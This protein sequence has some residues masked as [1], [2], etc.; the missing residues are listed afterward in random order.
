MPTEQTPEEIA[1]SHRIHAVHCNNLA[2]RL[3]ELTG[4]TP[5][6]DTEMLNA[7][8]AA[9]FHWSKVGTDLNMARAEMLL[10]HVHSAL[11]HGEQAMRY[12]RSSYEYIVAHDPPEWEIP[13]AHAV[14]AHAAHVFGDPQLHA[15]HYLIANQL[16]AELE[17][18]DRLIFYK[19]FDLIPRP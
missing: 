1:K 11:G 14:L 16:G 5:E 19:T 12:A 3:S 17:E 10:G 8:H 13:F 4:R 6:Q 18:E 9:A 7:S 15:K 2:W